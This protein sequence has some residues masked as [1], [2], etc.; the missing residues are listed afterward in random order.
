VVSIA[1]YNEHTAAL[2]EPMHDSGAVWG[3]FGT[4]TVPVTTA[5][6]RD[7]RDM[8]DNDEYADILFI[9][10]GEHVHA[11]RT[12]LAGRCEHFAAM[13]R[14]GMRECVEREITIPNVSK[15]VFL[16]LL[17]YIYTD[18]VMIDVEHAVDLYILADLY[19]LD[20]LGTICVTVVKRNMSTKNVTSLLQ[21]ASDL[22]CHVLRDIT[23][24]FVITNF[25]RISKTDGIRAV[26]HELLLEILS[27][28]P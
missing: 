9:V 18:S 3:A 22:G 14:S 28:R 10:D 8:V 12:I 25:E 1:S 16:L 5:F 27:N 24:E 6:V 4:N 23:M 17:E 20:R 13:F 21:H 15:A 7:M 26:S 19:G 2:V 11:H